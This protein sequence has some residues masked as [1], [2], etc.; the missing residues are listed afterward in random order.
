MSIETV[1]VLNLETGE[2]GL[3]RRD[4]F[5]NAAINNGILVEV[6]PEQKPYVA[7]LFKSKVAG[8]AEI[9]HDDDEIRPYRDDSIVVS[10]E[11]EQA[12]YDEFISNT[13]TDE[14]ENE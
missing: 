14:E 12:A 6:D 8:A 9:D 5:E 3:I 2:R 10:V 7:D 13:T 11:D 4:W 1:D